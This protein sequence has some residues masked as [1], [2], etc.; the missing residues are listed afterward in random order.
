MPVKVYMRHM[1][2]NRFCLS[3]FISFCKDRSFDYKTFFKNGITVP[4]LRKLMG[5]E[6]NTLVERA[7]QSAEKENK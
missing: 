2:Q 4:E 5:N 1:R 6:K 7:I 3:G